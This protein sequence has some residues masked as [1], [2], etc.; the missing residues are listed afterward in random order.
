MS[1]DQSEVRAELAARS[2]PVQWRDLQAHVLREAVFLLGP[3]LELLD[4]AVAVAEDDTAR[5]AAWVDGHQ[6]T[7]PSRAD[8]ERWEH[9]PERPFLAVVVQPFVL[10][11]P[12][13]SDEGFE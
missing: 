4:V 11:Q 1:R 5:V 3:D 7:R 9:E 13:D 2:G 12:I 6:L 10:A 8:L